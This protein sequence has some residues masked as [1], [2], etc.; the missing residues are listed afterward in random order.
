MFANPPTIRFDAPID[1]D[2]GP[3]GQIDGFNL[4]RLQGFAAHDPQMF[5]FAFDGEIAD[6]LRGACNQGEVV[7]TGSVPR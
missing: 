5:G 3:E 4:S 1:F 6:A 7:D 2:F